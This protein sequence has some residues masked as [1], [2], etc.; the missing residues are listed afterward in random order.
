MTD[1]T[2]EV[3][4]FTDLAPV[5]HVPEVNPADVYLAKL[6]P[7][8]RRTMRRALLTIAELL[9][10]E[11]IE[12]GA[13]P[14][15]QLRYEHTTLVRELL[16]DGERGRGYAPA[17]VNKH[18][19][20]LRGVLREAWRLGMMNTEHYHR[21]A[22]V[23]DVKGT[24]LPAGRSLDRGEIV[25]LF[26]VCGAD[27]RPQGRRD[28]ALLAVLYAGGLRRSEVVELNVDDYQP[29]TG[30][31]VVRGKGDR[32]RIV[33]LTNGSSDAMAAW[34]EVRGTEPGP[35]FVAV[36][37]S[38]KVDPARRRLTDQAVLATCTRRA[39]AAG[40]STFSPHDLR[41]T[42]VGDLLQ[43][44]ADL[45]MVQRLAGHATPSTTARYD[46]RPEAAKRR[47]AELLHVPFVPA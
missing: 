1:H 2:T 28:A 36:H 40:V 17:T 9:T 47:A 32:E 31:L 12:P 22:D 11:T 26:N 15:W 20:A 13:L 43:A 39:K 27:S 10:G 4:P 38:G 7:S 34:L 44:G 6:K 30:V 14:W 33:Y 45:A 24:R 19:A 37:R 21:A 29:A 41:R 3:Q 25:A 35:L 46:R 23:Q 8:G 5:G 18:L 16:A 42:M